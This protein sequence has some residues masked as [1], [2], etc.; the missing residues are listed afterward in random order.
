MNILLAHILTAA[1]QFKYPLLFIGTVIEGPILMLACGFL[2]RLG[3]FSPL[4]MFIALAS[5]DI[6]ADVGWYYVG[7]Y[8]F[9]PFMR[10]YG[11]FL[12]VTPKIVEQAKKLFHQYHTRVLVISKLTM[13]FG[14]A[15]AVLMVAGASR[16]PFRRYLAINVLGEIVFVSIML[17]LGY[18]FGSAYA[19]IAGGLRWLFVAGALVVGLAVTIGISRY[20]HRKLIGP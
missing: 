16:I 14:M 8:F 10:R 12:S 20:A 9:E 5:G 11:H 7:Q 3:V 1:N 4:P 6:V 15:V 19:V 18:V 13:G 2:L 17:T